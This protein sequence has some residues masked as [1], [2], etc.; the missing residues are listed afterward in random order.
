MMQ[1]N[2]EAHRN[3]TYHIPEIEMT[4]N[5]VGPRRHVFGGRCSRKFGNQLVWR[6]ESWAA[7]DNTPHY[8]LA[9]NGGIPRWARVGNTPHYLLASNGGIPPNTTGESL[10]PSP[11]SSN[12]WPGLNDMWPPL[13]MI[14]HN[15]FNTRGG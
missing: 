4:K 6:A 9:S 7:V 12:T 1:D 5:R 8:L 3:T 10:F 14:K 13:D 11:C 2:Q 15:I